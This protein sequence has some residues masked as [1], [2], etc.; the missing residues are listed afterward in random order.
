MS[1]RPTTDR[2]IDRKERMKIPF[3][4]QRARTPEDRV[5][6]FES[7]Y[8][9]LTPEE[10]R[11]AA[12]R[13]IHCPDPAACFEACPVHNDISAAM[14]LI[15]EGDF[16]GAAE[17][18][19]QT[20]SMPE[21]C[22]RVC[23]H[24]ILCMS[25]CVRNKRG[26]P[27]LTGALEAFVTDYQREHSEVVIP[28]G[29]PTGKRVAIVGAGPA[30]IGCAEQLVRM[31]HK[32]TIFEA[33]PAAGGLLR[34]G[35]P[36]FKLP[37][38][39]V[40]NVIGDL[41]ATGVEFVFDTRIGKERTIDSLFDEGFDAVFIGVGTGIDAT[42][43]APGIDLPRIYKATEF[44]TRSNVDAEYL[45]EDMRTKPEI[46]ERVA[47]IGGGDTASDCLRT[48]LRMGAKQVTCLYR[49][50]EAEMPGNVS[51]RKLTKEEGAK[52]RFLT[53]PV[54][55]IAGPDGRVSAVECL[56]CELG[57]P[58]ESGRR[59]PI[60]IE[61]S[62]FTVPADTVILALGYWPD[63]MI[64]ETTPDL[65]T[66]DWG[67]IT[68]DEETM[69]TSRPGVFAG[70]DAV[71]GPDLVVTAMRAGRIAAQSIDEYLKKD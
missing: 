9:P 24:E 57:E 66:H 51:D 41:E 12:E 14:W 38:D 63:E 33:Y 27:I 11:I 34:Y 4:E 67:L 49:R 2:V 15:E 44:L 69:A 19:R 64:G 32:A 5:K 71:T 54:R 35:I 10:A 68:V 42:M 60:P 45:P 43:K 22:G 1:E 47:V 31:G 40:D 70:G 29:E 62:N 50:T 46:G 25:S 30:G 61:G 28:L 52:F 65:E 55:Y 58:D 48:A 26:E 17:I 8:I 3:E 59:R 6:D 21:I 7:T 56:Q 16:I 37:K 18:Y 39:V 53:Q 23:P 13:C 36:N 20:S